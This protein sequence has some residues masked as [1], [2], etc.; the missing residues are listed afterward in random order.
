MCGISGFIGRSKKPKLSYELMTALFEHLEL[1][2]TDAAGV[3]ATEIDDGR[4]FYHKEPIRSSDFV[5]KQF[6]RKLG[7]VKLNLLLA[8]ARATSVG[9]GHASV[10]SNNHPFVSKDKRIGMVHNGILSEFQYLKD[11]YQILSDTDSEVLLRMYEHGLR[12]GAEVEEPEER[13]E[14][15]KDIWSYISE[16]AMAVAIG[17]RPH[18]DLRY[19]FLFHNVKRPLWIADLRKSLGQIF[20]FSSPEVWYRAISSSS[21]LKRSCAS[22]PD[23]IEIPVSQVW[24]LWLDG[25]NPMLLNT[26]QV[27]KYDFEVKPTTETWNAGDQL[28]VKQPVLE[29]NV[30]TDLD[31][32]EQVSETNDGWKRE[33]KRE[34]DGTYTATLSKEDDWQN[35]WSAVE[36]PANSTDHVDLCAQIADLSRSIETKAN[37]LMI[38]CTIS[39]TEYQELLE[40]LEQTRV[41]LEGTLR[42]LGG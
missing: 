30:V 25:D 35:Q 9:G 3:W 38:E 13:L 36:P 4:V 5:K 42:L 11:R 23:L 41:D 27:F 34:K 21:H 17:E 28:P 7:K 10:N 6:W 37:N 1:R 2:G 19:L 8:H 40:S 24:V 29:L 26:D 32:D 22:I 39:Q 15:I 16:G 14:G 31:E 20:F 18:P 33:R 12:D